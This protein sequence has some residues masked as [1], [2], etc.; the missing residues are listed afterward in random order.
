VTLKGVGRGIRGRLLRSG[1]VRLT[2][3]PVHPLTVSP[4]AQ[5]SA[6]V[7]PTISSLS[8]RFFVY[9]AVQWYRRPW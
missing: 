5:M 2:T 6:R 1:S 7:A 9:D 4:N 3:Q 8:L